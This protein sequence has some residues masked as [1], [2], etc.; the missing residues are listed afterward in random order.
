[1]N[2]DVLKF[3]L[4][5]TERLNTQDSRCT[6]DPM[7]CVQEKRRD[8]GYDYR[9]S[10]T[11]CWVDGANCETIYDDDKDFKEP[12]GDEWDEF[13]YVDRWETVMVAFTEEGCKEYIRQNGHNHRGELRI[14]VESFRRCPE[15]IGI[16]NFLIELISQFK[17]HEVVGIKPEAAQIRGIPNT[18]GTIVHFHNAEN[19]LLEVEGIDG[20]SVVLDFKTDE[21]IK[22]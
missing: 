22:L 15:M 16:R 5:I 6:A 1:M 10:D 11:R 13:G 7:F 14:Y 8:V 3:L 9:Y 17:E 2:E 21:L 12:K 18:S 20:E 19:A 4:S